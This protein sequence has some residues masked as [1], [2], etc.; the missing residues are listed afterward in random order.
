MGHSFRDIKG[1]PGVR[2]KASCCPAGDF[3]GDQRRRTPSAQVEGGAGGLVTGICHTLEGIIRSS[4]HQAGRDRGREGRA[5]GLWAAQLPSLSRGGELVNK[6]L[7][8]V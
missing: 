3:T 1:L 6:H 4:S 7:T 8:L 2:F 5:E